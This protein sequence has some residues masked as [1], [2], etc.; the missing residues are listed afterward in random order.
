[1]NEEH[2]TALEKLERCVSVEDLNAAFGSELNSPFEDPVI[3]RLY[4]A[5]LIYDRAS[6]IHVAVDDFCAAIGSPGA[7]SRF[8]D[9]GCGTG[10]VLLEIANRFR[11]LNCSFIGTDPS[12]EMIAIAEENR[13]G[14]SNP[15]N[16]IFLCGTLSDRDVI[17]QV[18]QIDYI[19]MRNTISWM[20]DADS[21]LQTWIQHLKVGG[22]IL[23]REL[24]RDASFPLLK[25]RIRQCLAFRVGDLTLAYPP[26]A[27][28]A[29]YRSAW[30]LT[31]ISALLDL[32]GISTWM[33]RPGENDD[34]TV[35][36]W[37][38]DMFIQGEKMR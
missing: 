4:D 35:E 36:P 38:V 20:K 3:A 25:T 11:H 33:T 16:V 12:A 26:S 15:N 24:R 17:K 19:L 6:M 28:V 29:A 13:G 2:L 23:I 7:N 9:V 27:M 18:Q 10:R 22:M 31:R 34:V 8:L 30:T 32:C 5:L 37:G 1:V 14:Y 21:E